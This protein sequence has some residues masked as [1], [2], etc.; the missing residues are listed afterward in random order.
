MLGVPEPKLAPNPD[1]PAGARLH[2]RLALSVPEHWRPGRKGL[3]ITDEIDKARFGRTLPLTERALEALARSA[4]KA[5]PIFG[6]HNRRKP[7][8]AARKRLGLGPVSAYD[9]RHARATHWLEEGARSLASPTCSG[10]SASRRR[11]AT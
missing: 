2:P 5:G 3:T 9:F 4:P 10:T 11:I 8:E 7:L 1:G 6:E